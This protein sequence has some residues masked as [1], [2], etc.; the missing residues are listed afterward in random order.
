MDSVEEC[1]RS[2]ETVVR[3]ASVACIVAML[4]S[5][6]ELCI[7]KGITDKYAD[8][9]NGLYKHLTNCDYQGTVSYIL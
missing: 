7:G 6:E 2:Q 9:I 8:K 4:G 1:S 3:G 5:L